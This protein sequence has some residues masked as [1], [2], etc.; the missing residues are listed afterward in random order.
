MSEHVEEPGPPAP[1]P[2]APTTAVA[3]PGCPDENALAELVQGLLDDVIAA[4]LEIHLDGCEE[5][6][7]IVSSVGQSSYLAARR[8]R[9]DSGAAA[10][11]AGSQPSSTWSMG[12]AAEL[13]VPAPGTVL[14][15]KYRVDGVLGQGGMG[16]V[17][18]AT[19]LTLGKLVALKLMRP[20]LAVDKGAAQRFVR[21]ARAASL[22][23]SEHIVR[24]IDLD[25]LPDGAPYIAMEYLEGEDLGALLARRGPIPAHEAATYI[26]QVC[27]AIAEAHAAGIVHRD[28]KPAN[29]FL[30]Q[31]ANT[32]C[33]KVLDFG[34]SKIIANSPL[35]DDVAS[36]DTKS[37]VGSPHYMA[38]EQL[39]SA[40]SVDPRTDVWA[41]G[42]ILY[43][44]VSGTSPFA[45][46]NA[47]AQVLASILRDNATPLVERCPDL[48]P[49]FVAIVERCL[50]KDP[51]RRFQRVD[52][53]AA[54]LAALATPLHVRREAP[55][56][57]GPGARTTAIGVG[58]P[59]PP[60]LHTEKVAAMAATPLPAPTTTSTAAARTRRSALAIVT[61]A[62]LAAGGVIGYFVTRETTS[63]S[64]PGATSNEPSAASNAAPS[65]AGTSNA[66]NAPTSNAPTA[67]A[68][69]SSAPSS[70]VPTSNA[71]TA[72]SPSTSTPASAGSDLHKPTKPKPR[73]KR[74]KKKLEDDL[75]G[76]SFD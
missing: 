43:E 41:L 45:S 29:L 60:P 5:C 16:V 57:V 34:V 3:P 59:A 17:L 10:Q 38:P 15:G 28:L 13:V 19:H 61:A 30:T 65:N 11:A 54:A 71:P 48:A 40:K 58:T 50:E 66:P 8:T 67:N 33:V 55:A 47:L 22:L 7:R 4:E 56:F 26:L 39:I 9:V 35:S 69:T 51:A 44:L 52:E 31:R 36:T 20:D 42:C 18:A 62:V 64:R 27:E 21:E 46:S 75:I 1:M 14:A 63:E 68:P 6:R 76:P 53:L 24:V 2:S 49:G 73:K 12:A 25:T 74:D 37:L 70:N 72:S 32:P 23:R